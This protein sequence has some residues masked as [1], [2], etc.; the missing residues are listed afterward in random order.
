MKD[1]YHEQ[2][3]PH[4]LFKYCVWPG[5]ARNKGRAFP[6]QTHK[7]EDSLKRKI[8]FKPYLILKFSTLKCEVAEEKMV[9]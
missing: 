9:N 3:S 5:A 2:L 8:P 1:K 4:E 6:V 7:Y